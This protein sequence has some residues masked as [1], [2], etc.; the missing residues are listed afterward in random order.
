MR[1]SP[2]GWNVVLSYGDL[3]HTSGYR[4]RILGEFH[5]IDRHLP[6]DPFLLVLDR[7]PEIFERAAPPEIAFRAIPRASVIGCFHELTNL[8]RMKP[9]RMVHAHNLY[10][11]GLAITAR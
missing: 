2:A 6:L 1:S 11:A 10:S 4:T 8:A 3:S 9:I 5:N 7:R